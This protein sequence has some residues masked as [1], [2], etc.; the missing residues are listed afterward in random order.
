MANGELQ[1]K[2]AALQRAML[3][4]IVDTGAGAFVTAKYAKYAKRGKEY[5]S[6]LFAYFAWFAVHLPSNNRPAT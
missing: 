2:S 3:K 5:W 6:F 1:L 4:L